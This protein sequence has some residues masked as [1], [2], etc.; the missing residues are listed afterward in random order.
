MRAAARSPAS[1]AL[2]TARGEAGVDRGQR[3]H[4]VAVQADGGGSL[5]LQL[6]GID[7]DAD[8]R[9]REVRGGGARRIEV[10][11]LGE[12][13]AHDEHDVG[14]RQG[15]VHRP[16]RERGAEAQRMAVGHDALGVDGQT[17]G[18]AQALGDR[19]GL[20]PRGHGASAQQ[21]H[22]A[23][24]AGEQLDRALDEFLVGDGRR[25]LRRQP[26]PG[27]RG[28]VEHVDRD[29]DVHGPGPLRL[30]DLERAR[31]R[32]G[33]IRR[34]ADLDRLGRDRGHER[35]LV[36]QVVKRSVPEAVV[37]AG[38]RA[39]DHEHRDRVVIGA[40]DRRCGV[41]EAGARDQRADAGLAGDARVAVGHERGALLVARRDVTDAGGGETAVDLE[42]VHA[43][44]A[45]HGV[46]VVLLEQ[47]DDGLAA[48][49]RGGARAG[50][51]IGSK[52]RGFGHTESV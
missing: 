5:P 33:Q 43:R 49:R 28:Q 36:G 8:D 12:L 11:G 38:S 26:L 45:E 10:V 23:L 31:E 7:V 27:R 9:P 2:A 25:P 51:R 47:A 52:W 3:R 50:G 37:G 41:R 18:R 16:Q 20:G 29:A 1:A 15:G 17:D 39:G 19:R 35:P 14:V 40:R 24:G 30:E 32:L 13:A 22:R 6:A 4:G 46:D 44:D 21:Q 42:R 34:I 48:A